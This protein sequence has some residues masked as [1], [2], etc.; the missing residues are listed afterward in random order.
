[1]ETWDVTVDIAATVT[2]RLDLALLREDCGLPTGT[3]LTASLCWRSRGTSLRGQ[4]ASTNL[5]PLAPTEEISLSGSLPGE[6]AAQ[7]V[8]FALIVHLTKRPRQITNPLAA[9][10]AGAVLWKSTRKVLIEGEAARFPV[11]SRPFSSSLFPTQAPWFLEWTATNL[12]DPLLGGVRLFLNSEHPAAEQMMSESEL[13]MLWRDFMRVDTATQLIRG[14]LS[15]DEFVSA[16]SSFAEGSIGA[17]VNSLINVFL[18]NQ[19]ARSLLAM[20]LHEPS[21]F[22][23]VLAAAFRVGSR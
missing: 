22:H 20:S 11:E 3:K 1:M 12:D 9:V 15:S 18:P 21:Q 5:S 4:L 6:C 2:A 16:P 17:H 13:G 10:D 19:T 14:C 23:A 7:E 8:D